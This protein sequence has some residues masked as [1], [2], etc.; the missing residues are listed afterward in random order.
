MVS[1]TYGDLLTYAVLI[2]FGADCRE[3]IRL[4]VRHAR[5]EEKD[6]ATSVDFFIIEGYSRARCFF[7]EATKDC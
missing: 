5:T 6:D 7:Q 1:S 4:F 2:V 3:V